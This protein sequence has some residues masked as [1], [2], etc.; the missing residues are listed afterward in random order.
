LNEENGGKGAA[1]DPIGD[2]ALAVPNADIAELGGK[3][4]ISHMP[5]LQLRLEDA[6]YASPPVVI[7]EHI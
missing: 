2:V 5:A 1:R 7:G 3:V 4:T 6:L